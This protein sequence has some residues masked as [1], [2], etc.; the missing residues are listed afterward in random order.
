MLK[1]DRRG[2]GKKKNGR[3]SL[4]LTATVR[5]DIRGLADKLNGRKRILK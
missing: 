5:N 1:N 3:P 2:R 4:L